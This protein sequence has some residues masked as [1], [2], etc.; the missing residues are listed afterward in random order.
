MSRSSP[1]EDGANVNTYPTTIK[2][3]SASINTISYARKFSTTP[4]NNTLK[5]VENSIQNKY[6]KSII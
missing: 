1:F 4:S 3:D 5:F 6:I 2:D